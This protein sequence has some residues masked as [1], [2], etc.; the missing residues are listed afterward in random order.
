MVIVSLLCLITYAAW[1]QNGW[2]NQTPSSEYPGLHAVYAI[3]SLNVWVAG[4]QGTI[5]HSLDGGESWDAVETGFEDSFTNVLF[6]NRDTG[7]ISGIPAEG[8]AFI[9]RTT[10][11]GESW[12]RIDLPTAV[13][14]MVNDIDFFHSEVDDTITIYAVGGLGHG[15]KTKDC[16]TTC[17]G[18]GGGCGNGNYN[19]CS[20]ID[21]NTAWFVGTPDAYYNHSIMFTSDGGI[22]FVEQI[23]PEKIKLNGVSFCDANHGIAVGNAYT[24]LSTDNGGETWTK[25]ECEGYRWWS[26]VLNESGKAWAVGNDGNIV[27]STDYGVTWQM[28]ES[29]VDS[30]LWDVSFINDQE[31]WVVGGGIGKPGIVLH[32]NTEGAGPSAMNHV[33]VTKKVALGQNVPNPF[34]YHTRISYQVQVPARVT[35]SLYDV[36]GNRLEQLVDAKQPEGSY[37][38]DFVN[39]HYPEGIYFYDLEV[40]S[41]RIQTHRMVIMK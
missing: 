26:V 33:T 28:Q 31:G 25:I 12:Q 1:S 6:L 21:E 9:L 37:C 3:D 13:Y 35:I 20:I 30:E 36:L 34:I 41:K 11:Q 8:D 16:F 14:T 4:E 32:M 7:F 5:L 19:A 29:G 27:H 24:V 39:D 23:N 18:L 10:D 15:W 2:T 38:F 22:S 17:I 40:D